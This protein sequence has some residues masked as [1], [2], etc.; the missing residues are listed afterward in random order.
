MDIIGIAQPI[1]DL[2]LVVDQIPDEN[3]FTTLLDYSSQGGGKVS[4]ALAA[5]ARLGMECAVAG[6]VGKDAKGQFVREDFIRHGIQVEQLNGLPCSFRVLPMF[7]TP[8]GYSL[9]VFVC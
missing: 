2:L 1:K 6:T 9:A 7:F 4:T 5:A 3:S 8:V